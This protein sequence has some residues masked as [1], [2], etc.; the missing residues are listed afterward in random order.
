MNKYRVT[1]FTKYFDTPTDISCE[2]I[3]SNIYIDAE[4]ESEVR[5]RIC[6]R[7]NNRKEIMKIEIYGTKGRRKNITKE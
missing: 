5:D 4:N 2:P 7:F 1:L 3:V 6:K